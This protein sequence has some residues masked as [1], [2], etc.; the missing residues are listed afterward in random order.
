MF[1]IIL[2]FIFLLMIVALKSLLRKHGRSVDFPSYR[3]KD[4][5]MNESE[6]AWYVNLQKVLGE[7]FIILSKVRIED[8]VEAERGE[9]HYGARG[10]IKSRHVDFLVF[11]CPATKPLFVVEVGGNSCSM[12]FLFWFSP[13]QA[14][15]LRTFR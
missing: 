10:R 4:R 1:W 14:T 2:V 9:N 13:M 12:T 3:K 8:F 7:C 5:V 6:Q 11:D 15:L